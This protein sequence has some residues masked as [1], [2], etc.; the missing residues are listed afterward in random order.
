VVKNLP[1]S[2]RSG[3]CPY[4]LCSNHYS[5]F[6]KWT[7]YNSDSNVRVV[8]RFG[9][10]RRVRNYLTSS[11]RHTWFP[12]R[13]RQ[14]KTENK[15]PLSRGIAPLPFCLVW[16]PLVSKTLS[17]LVW[18][19]FWYS[20]WPNGDVCDDRNVFWIDLRCGFNAK[21]CSSLP[22]CQS[23]EQ[24]RL[25][26]GCG[27]QS[28]WVR[29][30][31][32]SHFLTAWLN[33]ELYAIVVAGES[34]WSLS[35]P[36]YFCRVYWLRR[37]TNVQ[38]GYQARSRGAVETGVNSRTRQSELGQQCSRFCAFVELMLCVLGFVWIVADKRDGTNR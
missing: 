34:A 8:I 17:I 32:T 26:R 9:P 25:R 12:F 29:L 35:C 36:V 21:Q 2:Y 37:S 5:G 14:I 6:A 20:W 23:M 15:S 30:T 19:I 24:W 33:G 4:V 38:I 16:L 10:K 1:E 7:R 27:I 11:Q 18:Q 22:S 31:I 13:G 3:I 28:L